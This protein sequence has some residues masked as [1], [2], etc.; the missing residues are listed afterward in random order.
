MTTIDIPILNESIT[1]KHS[2]QNGSLYHICQY[3]IQALSTIPSLQPYLTKSDSMTSSTPMSRLWHFCRQGTSLCILFNT[4]KPD[5]PIPLVAE[6]QGLS[7]TTAQKPKAHVYHFII[8]CRDQLHFNPDTLFTLKDVF[9]DDTNGFVRVINLLKKVVEM[10]ES[11][12]IVVVPSSNYGSDTTTPKDT[13]DKI[14]IELLETERKYVQD[15]ETLQSY[16]RQAKAQEILPPDTIYQLFGN[17]NALV[18]C[19]RRFLIQVEAQA[20]GAPQEQRFGQLFMDHEEDFAVYEP[21]CSNFQTAQALVCREQQ[22]LEKLGHIL[23]PSF[24]LPSIL[25][26]PVQRLC[27]YPLLMKQLVKTTPSHWPFYDETKE[28]LDAIQRVAAKVN[29]TRRRQENLVIVRQLKDQID[30]WPASDI[31]D[32]GPLLL[33]DKFIVYRG[34]PGRELI[35][36]LFEKCL[37]VCREEKEK[38][39]TPHGKD[40]HSSKKSN[41]KNKKK[42]SVS[43]SSASSLILMSRVAQVN[44]TSQDGGAWTLQIFWSEKF[45]QPGQQFRL[46]SFT[47]K[48]RHQEQLQL[49]ESSLNRL[50]KQMKQQA[51]EARAQQQQQQGLSEHTM[52][53]QAEKE[54]DEDEDFDDDYDTYSST[55]T[56]PK[57]PPSYPLLP[58]HSS[59]EPPELMMPP[60]TASLGSTSIVATRLRSQSSPNIHPDTT[61]PTIP[62]CHTTS[63][64]TT[65]L[66]SS[67]GS[68]PTSTKVKVHHLDSIYVLVVPLTIDYKAL[69]ERIERKMNCDST[70]TLSTT[71]LAMTGLKYQ[72]EDGDLI[73]ISSNDD[74]QMG[75]EQRG[76]NNTVNFY[77]V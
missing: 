63:H 68:T 19:Q 44:D 59:S 60:N 5:T 23:S 17:L 42:D 43:A 20:I 1:H 75:F 12:G 4:L 32:F 2:T 8:A 72:D 76:I 64:Y 38:E 34:D 66:P 28:G 11:Q 16:M 55:I 40:G 71:A 41:K 67:L 33:H 35:V 52:V 27:K 7:I 47:L 57:T 24:E 13:R 65:K 45:L 3:I 69:V 61:I 46:D 62:T 49:W 53:N 30:D 9:Q 50:I 58:H 29:E 14:V 74:L 39:P 10:M 37:F 26:K 56:T 31:D 22:A 6:Q 54:E 25:I 18:D 15:L 36:Y 48:C 21:F 77:I 51:M 73:T 70:A